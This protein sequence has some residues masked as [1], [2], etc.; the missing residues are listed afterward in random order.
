MNRF[1]VWRCVR[2]RRTLRQRGAG[3]IPQRP[4][5]AA[6]LHRGGYPGGPKTNAGPRALRHGLRLRLSRGIG[7]ARCFA[8]SALGGGAQV[9]A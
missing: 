7:K 8:N 6:T 4:L 5:G 3:A 1:F 2:T 9:A